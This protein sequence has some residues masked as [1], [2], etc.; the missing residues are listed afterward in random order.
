MSTALSMVRQGLGLT[1]IPNSALG[2]M[3]GSDL[4][5]RKLE[6]INCERELGIIHLRKKT[7]T[8]QAQRFIEII[9]ENPLMYHAY[10]G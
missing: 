6:G 7:L 5:A 9:K 4:A 10:E 1:V 8:I 3:L 2:A